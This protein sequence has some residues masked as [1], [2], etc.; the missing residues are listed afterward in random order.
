MLPKFPNFTGPESIDPKF[1]GPKNYLALCS[2]PLTFIT[3]CFFWLVPFI[4]LF[5]FD[6]IFLFA[7]IVMLISRIGKKS[8]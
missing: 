6:E 4:I 3:V 7:N 1:T 8:I 5:W 2:F